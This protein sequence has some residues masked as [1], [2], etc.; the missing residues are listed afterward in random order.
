MPERHRSCTDQTITDHS[1][2]KLVE[3]E[4]DW[5]PDT[6]FAMASIMR[7]F[8]KIYKKIKIKI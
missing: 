6:E 5:T 2:Q 7:N 1:L 4:R 3:L 8:N